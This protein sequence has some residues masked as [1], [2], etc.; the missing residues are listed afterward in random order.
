MSSVFN[1]TAPPGHLADDVFRFSR[2]DNWVNVSRLSPSAIDR[3]TEGPYIREGHP[4]AP[5]PR[6]AFEA[7][8][9]RR[10]EMGTAD[11]QDRWP[12]GINASLGA[13]PSRGGEDQRTR[14]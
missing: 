12:T 10:Q 14:D 1:F 9:D 7:M 6:T 3:P 4:Q 2:L 13:T 8:Q 11:R 5:R